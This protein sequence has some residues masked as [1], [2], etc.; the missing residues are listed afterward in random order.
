M[1]ITNYFNDK[2]SAYGTAVS[3]GVFI[4]AALSAGTI[5]GAATYFVAVKNSGIFNNTIDKV[6]SV[7]VPGA[8]QRRQSSGQRSA[9]VEELSNKLSEL[10]ARLEALEE[11]SD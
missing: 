8:G 9:E 6:L 10:S 7:V 4:G 1:S 2:I 3:C 11:K 5:L